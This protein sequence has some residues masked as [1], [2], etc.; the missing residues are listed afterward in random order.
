MTTDLAEAVAAVKQQLGVTSAPAHTISGLLPEDL[1]GPFWEQCI[2][3]YLAS[4]LARADVFADLVT[5]MRD[6][7]QAHLFAETTTC[8]CGFKPVTGE[9]WERHQLAVALQAI[10]PSQVDST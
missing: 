8:V 5:R 6:A 3:R 1:R 2:D 4:E 7:Q 10:L 9:D